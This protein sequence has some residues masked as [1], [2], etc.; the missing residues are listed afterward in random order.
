MID[1][2]N[3]YLNGSC[4]DA[5]QAA[6]SKKKC[7]VQP[8]S[9]LQ[10]DVLYTEKLHDNIASDEQKRTLNPVG[11][12]FSGSS[13]SSGSKSGK[14]LFIGMKLDDL[15][16]VPNDGRHDGDGKTLKDLLPSNV[17]YAKR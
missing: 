12:D 13:G 11:L 15:C 1:L 9:E 6:I 7:V 2:R 3:E 14:G 8:Y 17:Q 10:A 4:L 5:V 16:I